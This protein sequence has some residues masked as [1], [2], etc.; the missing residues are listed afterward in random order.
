MGTDTDPG[1]IKREPAS[2]LVLELE[3]E[4][5]DSAVEI[6]RGGF[7]A[8]YRCFQ[9]A[10]ER[11]VAIKVLSTAIDKENL[12]RFLREE[13]AMGRLSGHPNIV[14]ILHIGTTANGRQ[15]IV[16]PFHAAGSY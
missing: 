16:M 1:D 13:K 12:E 15:Y 10:L 11:T 4:G 5:L 6:G 14:D 3:A 2:D 7:G 8:V 9:R